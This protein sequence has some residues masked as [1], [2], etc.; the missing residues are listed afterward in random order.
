MTDQERSAFFGELYLR[1][2]L[3]FLPAERTR[4]EI[5]YLRGALAGCGGPLLDLGCGHGRHAGPLRAAGLPVIGLDNDALSLRERLPGTVA[6]RGDLRRLPLRV[7]SVGGA[8]SWYSSLFVFEDDDVHRLLLREIARALRPGAKLVLH[9]LP[10]E[11]VARMP[12]ER[13]DGRLPDGAH[14]VE[15]SRFDPATG[16]DHGARRLTLKDGRVLSGRFAIRYYPLPELTQLLNLAGF[17]VMWVHG[18]VD[19]AALTPASGDLIL[20]VERRHG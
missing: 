9:T 14:L 8:Y 4:A 5:A 13:F 15:E 2:T 11:H 16:R 6:L 17:S 3:P 12:P 19:G 20:G 18:G 10:Y 1:S 7:G